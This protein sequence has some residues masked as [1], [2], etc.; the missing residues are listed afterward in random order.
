MA[1]WHSQRPYIA[2]RPS[3]GAVHAGWLAGW[4]A[5][6]A[7]AVLFPRIK[8]RPALRHQRNLPP[9]GRLNVMQ[10]GPV[11]ARNDPPCVHAYA[12]VSQRT[13][14]STDVGVTRPTLRICPWIVTLWPLAI[15]ICIGWEAVAYAEDGRGAIYW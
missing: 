11:P 2:A 6:W 5:R 15:L 1:R 7:I 3:T 9:R 8:C 13:L 14:Y 12:P 10:E 4:L